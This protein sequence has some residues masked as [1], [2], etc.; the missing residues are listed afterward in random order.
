MIVAF[1]TAPD[2]GRPNPMS[3]SHEGL[4]FEVFKAR[5]QADA[6]VRGMAGFHIRSFNRTL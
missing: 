6:A 5:D 1:Y 4:P 3:Q 2:M